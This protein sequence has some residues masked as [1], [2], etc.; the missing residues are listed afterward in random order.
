VHL[1]S[2]RSNQQSSKLC[3]ASLVIDIVFRFD[4]PCLSLCHSHATKRS[5]YRKT[6]FKMSRDTQ[7][8]FVA[9]VPR[10]APDSKLV[11]V[12]VRSYAARFGRAKPEC[13][14]RE[15][16]KPRPTLPVEAT[17]AP[18]SRF[19]PEGSRDELASTP[20]PNSKITTS[21]SKYTP[22][23]SRAKHVIKV[24]PQEPSRGLNRKSAQQ[25]SFRIAIPSTRSLS[26]MSSYLE[27]PR[28]SP[29][30]TRSSLDPFF[31]TASNMPVI[32]SHLLHLC[33]LYGNKNHASNANKI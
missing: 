12:E 33:T 32:D 27:P 23:P 14:H 11:P 19:R 6:A 24:R 26:D 15:M 17:V 16:R 18:K 4:C 9:W 20:L 10:P 2:P 29:A 22:V 28:L 13:H 21:V 1:G 25:L 30:I 3:V 5:W 31:R 8:G 7:F